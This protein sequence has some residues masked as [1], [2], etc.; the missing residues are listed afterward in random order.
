ML[1]NY[2]FDSNVHTSSSPN[3]IVPFI[4]DL[5]RPESVIDIGCGLGYWL[6]SFLDHGVRDI[7]GVDGNLG[8]KESLKIPNDVIV[9][10]D[11]NLPYYSPRR[12]DLVLCLELAE[13]LEMKSADTLIESLVR[14]SDVV[15][16]SAAIP[17]QNGENHINL[18]WPT[19]WKKK[20]EAY[21]FVLFDPVRPLFWS[22]PKVN[23]WYKQNM[24]LYIHECKVSKYNVQEKNL[25][26]NAIHPELFLKKVNRLERIE[27]GHIGLKTLWRLFRKSISNR[28]NQ[29]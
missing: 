18:Q 10:H 8:S 28:Y 7:L 6:A 29:G 17:G 3:E 22:N 13:H 27:N 26:L 4:I 25:P 23:Y 5:I 2:C 15:L 19:F 21:G 12:F 20:F 9:L 1:N 14:L 24:F 11:L 16:F